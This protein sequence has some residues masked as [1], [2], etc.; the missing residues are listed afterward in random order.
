MKTI[1]LILVVLSS[2]LAAACGLPF[3]T[4]G[5]PPAESSEP[6]APATARSTPSRN[7]DAGNS[8]PYASFLAPAETSKVEA[9][10]PDAPAPT[11]APSQ[12]PN[13]S[14]PAIT[15]TPFGT[16]QPTP[17]AL[18]SPTPASNPA[19]VPFGSGLPCQQ[20][21]RD[22]LW[23]ESSTGSTQVS[24]GEATTVHV[25]IGPLPDG[26]AG[27]DIALRVVNPLV[28]EVVSTTMP[29]FGLTSVKESTPGQVIEFR[30]VDLKGVAPNGTEA[31]L[32]A[33]LSLEARAIGSTPLSVTIKALDDN[34]GNPIQP[35]IASFSLA[36]SSP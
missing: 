30:A 35:A 10:S 7:S 27:F 25:C 3:S 28:A 31:A 21:P 11:P 12:T 14:Q 19:S 4:S 15:P 9:A 26:L 24:V 2:L 22:G 17:F 13:A 36:V 20:S 29:D 33:T 1:A 16:P 8:S 32:L 34:R 6:N 18:P 23:I 5:R